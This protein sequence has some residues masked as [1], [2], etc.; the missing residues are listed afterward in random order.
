MT[1]C[2]HTVIKR[3]PPALLPCVAMCS[4]SRDALEANPL[5]A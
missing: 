1:V 4:D 2:S 3:N 5:P